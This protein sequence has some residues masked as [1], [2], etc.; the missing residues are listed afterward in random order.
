[1]RVKGVTDQ[2]VIDHEVAVMEYQNQ[3]KQEKKKRARYQVN[4]PMKM[5]V[6]ISQLLAEESEPE[7]F[8]GQLQQDLTGVETDFKFQT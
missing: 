8:V 5:S 2:K 6:N 3:L 1:M 7:D 4:D